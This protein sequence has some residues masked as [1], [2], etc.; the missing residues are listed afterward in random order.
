MGSI[1]GRY[2]RAATF[3]E[4]HGPAVGVVVEGLPAGLPVSAEL[5]QR[6]LDRRRPGQSAFTSAR[7]EADQVEIL[8]GVGADGLS[9][10]TPVA[11]LVRNQD[12]RSKDYGDIRRLFR[13]GHAD[14]TYYYKYGT[15]PQPGGGRASGRETVGRVAAGA[16]AR[17][18]LA[19]L[20]VGIQACTARVGG[21]LALARDWAFAQADPLRCPDPEVAQAMAE[22][23]RQ[24]LAE[25][26]SLGGVVE[27]LASG[28]PVGLGDPVADKLDALLAGAMLGI[29]GVKGL[30]VGDGF[31][32]ASR[33][34]SANNDQ[35]S[36]Q[37]FLSNHAGGILGGI[38]TGQDIV[39]RLAVK[40]TPSIARP[41]ATIDLDGQA[42][43][44]EIK[45]RHDPCLC[46]RIAPVAEAMAALVLAD[47]W[48][49]Q[50]AA[51]QA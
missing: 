2:L 16:L 39:L 24:A 51:R 5:I 48:L 13:P 22:A 38:S 40:P 31:A 42:R 46:P 20:G 19:P 44:M 49:A 50:R 36:P 17:A 33:R 21:V 15:P 27:V 37:G 30:E 11:L 28:V 3:G 41:Q 35:I 34:G 12:A 18:L 1:F 8:S 25:G 43:T 10:G 14:Y 26:D 32:V 4:S 29:G 23:V 9:L 7:R 47:A 45:G 6:D